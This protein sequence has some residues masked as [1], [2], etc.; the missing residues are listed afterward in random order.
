MFD[1]K[2]LVQSHFGKALMVGMMITSVGGL[3]IILRSFFGPSSAAEISKDRLFVC[4]ATGK[5]FRRKIQPGIP[6]PVTS[7]FTGTATGYEAELCYWTRD[8]SVSKTPAAVLLNR[9]RGLTEPT[10]CPDCGRLVIQQNP[11]PRVGSTPPPH[12][13]E[14]TSWRQSSSADRR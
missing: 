9:Y 2:G 5:S 14:F 4:A 10:F 13:K 3:I 8:G 12:Q 7:P 1:F 11:P 6:I